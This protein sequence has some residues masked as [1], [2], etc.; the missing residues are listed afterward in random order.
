M[1][2]LHIT[3]STNGYE[4]VELIANKY[5]S[6]ISLSV[7]N[8]NEGIRMTGGFI[9]ENT[10]IIRS[11]LD[12]IPKKEQYNFIKSFRNIPFV[13]EYYEEDGGLVL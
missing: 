7:I 8:T 9:L 2:V 12:S 5:N 6:K 3:P 1:E 4:I 13:K 11:V 10:H